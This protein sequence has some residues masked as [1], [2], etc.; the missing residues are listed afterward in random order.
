MQNYT[1]GLFGG[2]RASNSSHF[3]N[4]T[5]AITSGTA[6]RAIAVPKRK[7]HCDREVKFPHPLIS[8]FWWR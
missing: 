2:I 3:I 7:S 8:N 5:H 4:L 1:I 6:L